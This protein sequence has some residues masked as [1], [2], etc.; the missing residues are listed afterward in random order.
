MSRKPS[1]LK[2][3]RESIRAREKGNDKGNDWIAA[4]LKLLAMTTRE[5]ARPITSRKRG[6]GPMMARERAPTMT[7]E[8]RGARPVSG[9]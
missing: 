3:L 4:S 2:D 6:G 5:E 1:L 8:E 9:G 7:A